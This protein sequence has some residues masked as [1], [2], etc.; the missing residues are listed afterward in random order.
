MTNGS[1]G[2]NMIAGIILIISGLFSIYAWQSYPE[3]IL[4]TIG[5]VLLVVGIIWIAKVIHS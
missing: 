4:L 3:W 1:E 5:I 2:R